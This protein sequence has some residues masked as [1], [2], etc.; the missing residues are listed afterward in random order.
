[1]LLLF[2]LMSGVAACIATP[3]NLALP[4]PSTASLATPTLI[5]LPDLTITDISLEF[6]PE[7][8]CSNT[9][10][11]YRIQI[12]VKNQGKSDAG[13]FA[14]QVNDHPLKFFSGLPAKESLDFWIDSPI[15]QISVTV[16]SLSEIAENNEGNN[17]VSVELSL[18]TDQA[19][20][21]KPSNSKSVIV[22]AIF[23]LEGHSDKVLSVHFSP[24][25]NLIASGSVDN[26]LRL[27]QTSK[28]SLLRTMRGHPFPVVAA[29]F[30]PDGV[31]LVTGS[32]DG[33]IRIWRVSDGRLLKELH[34][35]AGRIKSLDISNDGR[36]II[37]CA[38]DYTV[39][40]WRMNDFSMTQT[41]DEGMA[42]LTSVAFAP[43]N[44][45][46]AWSESNGTVRVRSLNGRWLHKFNETPISA[47]SVGFDPQGEWISAG[48]T[49]GSI[50]LW[51][52]SSGELV[53]TL[54]SHTL[55]VTELEFSPDGRW[56]ASGSQDGLIYIWLR[57]AEGFDPDPT[58]VLSGHIAAVNCISFSPNGDQLASAS[59]DHSI[60]IWK[61]PQE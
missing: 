30:S 12:Q 47:N 44:Q 61:I 52:I 33:L 1:M 60:R 14:V 23:T 37:S 28:G 9:I 35:H 53:Q 22:E 42:E 36:Y 2:F 8:I 27:W 26:T 50:H 11:P 24:D 17:R 58:F 43:D 15:L 48:F 56:L 57:G 10:A 40:V 19:A 6:T 21:V 45:T 3:E 41:I 39:R 20:C 54:K 13:P 4:T 16:D 5:G 59:S 31:S 18:P 34:G 55:G 46:I 38:D 32:T 49:D 7:E 25:G 29:E 51:D